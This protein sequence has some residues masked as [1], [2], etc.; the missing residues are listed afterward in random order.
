MASADTAT[1][2]TP[3][4]RR[5]SASAIATSVLPTP[6]GPKMAITSTA[7]SIVRRVSV[8]IATGLSTTPDARA[9][10]LEAASA[11]A[12]ALHGRACDLAVVF[13]SGAHLAEPEVTLAA[14]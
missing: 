12:R 3:S 10:A 7:R 8:H 2:S 6:V 9:G 11:A 1:G 5:R 14:V 4:A 13:A